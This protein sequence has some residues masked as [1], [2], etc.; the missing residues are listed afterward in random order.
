[1]Q[2][3]Q[4]FVGLSIFSPYETNITIL[5][6]HPSASLNYTTSIKAG[7]I[8]EYKLPLALRMTGT[9][10]QMNGIEILSTRNVSVTCVNHNSGTADAYLALPVSTLGLTYVVASYSPGNLGIVSAYDGNKVSLLLA[11]DAVLNYQGLSYDKGTPFVYATVVLKKLEA[12]HIYSSSDLSG[13]VVIASKPV[14]V[15]SGSHLAKPTGSVGYWDILESFM[16]PTHL[17][18]MRY[19]LSTFG[20]IEKKKGDI[21]RIFAYENN[22]VVETAYWTKVLSPGTYTELDLE[23]NPASF[24]KCNKPCQVVQFFRG[25]LISGKN[26]DSSMIVLPSVNQFQSY[27]RVVFPFGSEYHDSVTIMVENE[28]HN[29]LYVDGVRISSEGWKDINGTK[30]VWKVLNFAGHDSVTIYHSSSAVRFG[31]LVFG[32]NIH[33]SYAYPGGLAFSNIVKGKADNQDN[34]NCVHH[35]HRCRSHL[36]LN[37]G[38][39][40]LAD[41]E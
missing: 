36:N 22:T 14:A 41:F 30:Y 2:Y 37:V 3:N 9:G 13:T 27:Y 26:A 34:L 31:L 12:L 32:W 4:G 18:G 21:F 38:N 29:E 35:A 39:G 28:H 1:M 40:Y 17:W 15:I 7:E 19:I 25:E 20:T 23:A 33:M 24:V 8:F 16:L 11:K 10:K 6:K 5:S